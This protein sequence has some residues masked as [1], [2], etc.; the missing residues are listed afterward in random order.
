MFGWGV[1]FFDLFGVFREFGG[2][3]GW[4]KDGV[5]ASGR[6]RH[7]EEGGEL[8]LFDITAKLREVV[9]SV[10]DDRSQNKPGKADE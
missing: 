2:G 1:G 4:G 9:R 10:E 3:R 5:G 6:A 7:A 8:V